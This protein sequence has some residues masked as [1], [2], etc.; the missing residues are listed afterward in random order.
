[1]AASGPASGAITDD[2]N[3]RGRNRLLHAFSKAYNNN[4]TRVCKRRLV[5]KHSTRKPIH[6]SILSLA[7][8]HESTSFHRQ[9]STR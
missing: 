1:M 3:E 6:S 2:E 9:S 7:T 4:N 5:V 8:R